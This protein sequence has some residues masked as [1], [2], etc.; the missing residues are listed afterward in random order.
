MVM[1]WA[2]SITERMARENG[3]SK[4]TSQVPERE[5]GERRAAVLRDD[6]RVC[7]CVW[8]RPSWCILP[9]QVDAPTTGANGRWTTC[10]QTLETLWH[11]DSLPRDRTKSMVEI[12]SGRL[13]SPRQDSHVVCGMEEPRGLTITTLARRDQTAGS[14][15]W[16]EVGK[17]VGKVDR[18]VGK[19]KPDAGFGKGHDMT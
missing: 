19:S 3:V 2:R 7:M 6:G 9:E 17:R 12:S 14:E 4:P 8:R 5:Q 15:V 1:G 13:K 18:W 16:H 10:R 11:A